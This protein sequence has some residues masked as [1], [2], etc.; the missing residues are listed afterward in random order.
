MLINNKAWIELDS[1]WQDQTHFGLV[2]AR[3]MHIYDV[4]L[5][6]KCGR[7]TVK[8]TFIHLCNFQNVYVNINIFKMNKINRCVFQRTAT[9]WLLWVFW[10]MLHT[11]FQHTELVFE[12]WIQ[13]IGS[14]KFL[15][16]LRAALGH[17]AVSWG[18]RKS[19]R[20]RPSLDTIINQCQPLLPRERRRP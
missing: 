17:T 6:S 20:S 3:L 11:E 15:F 4:T 16:A 18:I 10:E 8:N 14:T 1:C 9:K 2:Y 13:Q 12:Y 5:T 7:C 19:G